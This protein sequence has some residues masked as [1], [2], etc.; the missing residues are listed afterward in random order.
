MDHLHQGTRAQ[1]RDI[2]AG[3]FACCGMSTEHSQSTQKP[4]PVPNRYTHVC[5]IF[6][7]DI[8]IN[9]CNPYLQHIAINIILFE[10]WT[11]LIESNTFNPSSHFC[12]SPTLQVRHTEGQRASDGA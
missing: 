5:D 8:A 4:P 2:Q 11:K 1:H 6:D 3:A 10:E 12:W 9:I 7:S